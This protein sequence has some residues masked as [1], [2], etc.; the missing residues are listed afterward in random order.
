M[1]AVICEKF[2][3]WEALKL[4]DVPDPVVSAGHVVIDVK[5]AGLNFPDLLLVA[6]KYQMKPPLPFIPGSECAG[7]ICEIG[8]GITGWNL[9]DRVIAYTMIGA[10][11]DKVAVPAASLI[12]LP[13]NM[14][15][16]NGAGLTT[17][18]ATS[19]YALKQRANLQAGETVLVLGAAGGV[20][21]A[22]VELAKAMGANVIAG[23]SS[24]EKL[25]TAKAHGADHLINYSTQ[26]LKEQ[27]KEIT[28]GKGVDVIYDPVGGDL[29]ETAFR[30]IGFNGRFLVVGFADGDI[31]KLPLN[32]PLLKTAS[33]IGVFWGAWAMRDPK[34]HAS[35][36]GEIISMFENGKIK[37]TVSKQIRFADFSEGFADLSERRAQGKLVLLP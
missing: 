16:A 1:K 5:A 25:A 32:L 3:G 11:A 20:G 22:A 33:I 23:A 10:M 19:Y 8:E 12:P 35:N 21:L 26:S 9:G 37:V 24:D 18:Y 14:P 30:S 17:T 13:E 29:S 34:A 7:I 36:M 27:I 31:P 6:G 28:K 15:F 4:S 2:D